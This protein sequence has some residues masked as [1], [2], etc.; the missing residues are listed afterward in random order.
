[1]IATPNGSQIDVMNKIQSVEDA[2]KSWQQIRAEHEAQNFPLL[3]R[4]RKERHQQAQFEG[5]IFP[6]PAVYTL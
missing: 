6:K 4:E 3:L 5:F 2:F 1:M